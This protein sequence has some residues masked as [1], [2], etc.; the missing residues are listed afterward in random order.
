ML[1]ARPLLWICLLISG[2]SF[3]CTTGAEYPRERTV[4]VSQKEIR[5]GMAQ[6]DVASALGSPTV[7]LTTDSGKETWIYD[8][9]VGWNSYSVSPGGVSGGVGAGFL[10]GS[11]LIL[12]GFGG[13]FPK[14]IVDSTIIQPSLTLVIK[15]NEKKKIESFVYCCH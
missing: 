15:F 14:V 4:D 9:V 11:A 6:A 1:K 10:P 8:K 5:V 12:G 7:V 3:G 2:L 13:G